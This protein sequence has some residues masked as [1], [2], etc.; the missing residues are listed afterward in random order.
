MLALFVFQ[1]LAWR[2]RQVRLGGSRMVLVIPRIST[3]GMASAYFQAGNVTVSWTAPT[4]LMN[5]TAVSSAIK[6]F[7]PSLQKGLN[8]KYQKSVTY[9]KCASLP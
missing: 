3:A 4:A 1:R 5:M 6:Y 7:I 8:L 9:T 2:L